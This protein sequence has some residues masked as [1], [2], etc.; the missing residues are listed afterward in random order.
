MEYCDDFTPGFLHILLITLRS[1]YHA[2]VTIKSVLLTQSRVLVANIRSKG[3]CPCPRC[4]IPISR[5]YRLGMKQDTQQRESL[6]RVDDEKR[7]YAVSTARDIIYNKNYAVNSKVL[8][9]L[10]TEQSLTPTIVSEV[11]IDKYES[12]TKYTIE[13][14][15]SVSCSIWLQHV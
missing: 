6:A 11:V 10:L 3:H 1:A 8:K 13:C 2:R 4:L 14:L 7:R 9:P 12:L 15:F 5:F